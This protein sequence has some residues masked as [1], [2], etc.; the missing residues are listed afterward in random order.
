VLSDIRMQD[1]DGWYLAKMVRTIP[2]HPKILFITGYSEHTVEQVF[3]EGIDGFFEK[4]FDA[5][6]VKNAILRTCVSPVARWAILPTNEAQGHIVLSGKTQAELVEKH[7][8]FFGRGGFCFNHSNLHFGEGTPM[9]FEIALTS[10]A[11][12][13]RIKGSGVIKWRHN[14]QGQ[15]DVGYGLEIEYLEGD[16]P[17]VYHKIFGKEMA[18]IPSMNLLASQSA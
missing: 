8:L 12:F 14:R 16:G 7:G 10:Q 11:P 17:Q 15:K 18:W 1:G 6:A 13:T 9:N 3:H 2:N 5:S 4:P